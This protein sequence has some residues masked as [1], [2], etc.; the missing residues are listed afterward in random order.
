MSTCSGCNN[1]TNVYYYPSN[2]RVANGRKLNATSF[3]PIASLSFGSTT[4]EESLTF[5]LE[6]EFDS[7]H[8]AIEVENSCF[9]LKRL[10]VSYKFCS[11]ETAGLV[12]Y[13]N[14]PI[15]ASA[16]V[17][18][19]SCKANAIVSPNA[20]L[21]IVCNTNGT[22][23]GSPNCSCVSGYFSMGGICKGKNADR[24]VAFYI[25]LMNKSMYALNKYYYDGNDIH[26]R[27][28]KF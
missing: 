10:R 24:A 4:T 18:S 25:V 27:T 7:F 13:P 14:T 28:Q 1:V 11:M 26:Q 19:A 2:A 21:R 8:I 22:Y 5:S 20:F 16:V 9:T 3:I 15:G 12:I 17:S 23:S 6:R